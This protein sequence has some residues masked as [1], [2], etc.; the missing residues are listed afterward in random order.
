T[1]EQTQELYQ[2]LQGELPEGFMLK[3][4]PKLSGKMAFTIIYVLQE[5][6]KL[7]PD[8]FEH[9]ERCDVVFD[10]DFGGDHFDDPGINLCDSCVSHVFWRLAK[11]EKDNME[12]AV[13]EWYA[14]LTNNADMEEGE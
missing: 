11:G 14:E 8:H 13:K 10:M 7:I 3:T 6:F 4:P 5:K 12:N 1:L 2:F 9:C